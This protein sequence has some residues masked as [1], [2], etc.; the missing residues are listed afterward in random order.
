MAPSNAEK[1]AFNVS[2]EW[3]LCPRKF[4][5]ILQ[6]TTPTKCPR[7]VSIPW[8]NSLVTAHP[9]TL[10][11]KTSRAWTMVEWKSIQ[12][13]LGFLLRSIKEST[14]I[15]EQSASC[16]RSVCHTDSYFPRFD[17]TQILWS[18]YATFEARGIPSI[19]IRTGLA[20]TRTNRM[21]N[22]GYTTTYHNGTLSMWNIDVLSHHAW[23]YD[24]F[25]LSIIASG[26]CSIV[27]WF[28]YTS[29]TMCEFL[30]QNAICPIR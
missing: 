8:A 18:L 22:V 13:T 1:C 21:V 3:L 30:L 15:L 29:A 9:G 24:L 19:P 6:A 23:Y 4:T 2:T 27:E 28:P 17:P 11:H 20:P 25:L 26:P 7:V 10:L 14:L 12:W 5:V 16:Y